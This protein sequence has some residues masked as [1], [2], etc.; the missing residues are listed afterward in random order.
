M[1]LKN[2]LLAGIWLGPVKPDMSIILKPILER[3]HGL[4]QEGITIQTPIG[5]KCLR[6]KLLCCVFDLPARAMALNLIQWNGHY[7]CTYCE[8]E[9]TQKSHVRLYLP[10]DEHNSRSEKDIL[11]YAEKASI[12]SPVF[13]VKGS[14]VLSPYLNIVKDTVVDYMHAVLEGVTKT[15][16][17][18]FWFNGKY[19]DYRFYLHKEVKHIDE[20]LLVIR[21]PHEFRR[22][23]RSLEKTIKYWKA[24]ELRAW[25]LFYCIPI[26]L[27]F[28]HVDY[29]HHLYLLVK[30]MH[31]LLSPHIY[32]SDL[33]AAERMLTV[34]YEKVTDLY[35]EE[36]CTMNVHSLIHLTQTVKNFGPLWAYS[37]FGF[38]SMNGHLKKHCHG[39]RNVLP[40]LV[41][42][43]RFHQTV[44][45]ADYNAKDHEDGVRGRVK[46]KRLSP[47]FLQALNEGNYVTS[48]PIFPVFCRY[49]QNGILYK[50]WKNA[51][52][53]RNSSVC[54]FLTAN[55]TQLFGS[56]QYFCLSA[57]VPVA[58]I[59]AFRPAK[60]AF[61]GVE[62][63][64]I[65]DLN[66]FSLTNS[67]VFKVEKVQQ[68]QAVPVSSILTKCVCISIPSKP[69]YFIVTVPNSYEHH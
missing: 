32:S 34:F 26:L 36:L 9:G 5:R 4:Y 38:E 30:A 10:D 60:D 63:A 54:K 31:I 11:K 6:A 35:P 29:V 39:T 67:C 2:L 15:L 7:G 8:D 53:L 62:R 22:S 61:E 27:E 18:K 68:L 17:L 48:N 40:Q 64:T 12:T 42:N 13:G 66:L 25:L 37:C 51:D 65:P 16:L 49:K 45:D 58:I 55:G 24:S 1:N 43:L 19:K 52:Q 14:S 46:Q 50:T 20:I 57:T 56:I 3:I 44:M 33:L 23:P 59:A 47:E 28:L 69:Y 21:P 41:H